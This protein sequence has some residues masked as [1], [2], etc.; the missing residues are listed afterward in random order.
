MNN[1]QAF[2]NSVKYT[3][4]VFLVSLL[5]LTSESL[6]AE[7]GLSTQKRT[8]IVKV[9]AS[10][11]TKAESL[12]VTHWNP[13]PEDDWKVN[14]DFISPDYK[15]FS[16]E[17][18]SND[19]M[20]ME[21]DG[22]L[23]A[24]RVEVCPQKLKDTL[25]INYPVIETIVILHTNDHHFDINMQDELKE[26]IT[27][28]RNRYPDVFLFDAG[29]IFVR[30]PHR[31]IVN[32]SL[33]KEVEWYGQRAMEMVEEM[34]SLG[35]HAMTLGNHELDYKEPYTGQALAAAEFP[36]LSANMEITTEAIPAPGSHLHFNTH[37][38]R[39]LSV[40]GLSVASANQPG[41][42][43]K[44]IF[45]T[46]GEYMYLSEEADV[47][48]ALTHIGLKND[49]R[50]AEEFSMLDIIIGGH[51]HHFIEE[52]VLVNEVLIAQAG[53]NRHQVSDQH[54]VY[55]GKITVKLENGKI[56]HK[57]GYVMVIGEE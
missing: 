10:E 49:V 12:T 39:K 5:L 3:F 43:E 15:V 46:A 14:T 30:H 34:N 27:E 37:T 41:I 18:K 57:E 48:V 44:D 22:N 28:I 2:L 26:K 25:F 23:G 35:Y 55:L 11:Q 40:L 36:L 29:D 45:E 4:P 13:A 54:P 19:C 6:H 17:A 56:A 31:W 16:I 32:D 47:F 52:A 33:V 42:R 1:T 21:V 38:G 9:A 24:G 7:K 50:L 51:S 8:L 53:G 20:I